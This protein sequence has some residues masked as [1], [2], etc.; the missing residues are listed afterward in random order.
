M[1]ENHV[2]KLQTLKPQANTI[3]SYDYRPVDKYLGS[4]I[5][6]YYTLTWSELSTDVINNNY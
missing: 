2:E 1:P 3:N 4:G 5:Q 6:K